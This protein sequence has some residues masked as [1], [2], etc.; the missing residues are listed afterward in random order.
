MA[1]NEAFKEF[2]IEGK[3]A[4][5]I[6]AELP[7]G[8]AA[9][10][11]LAEAGA[12]VVLA[13]QEPGTGDKLKEL[14]KKISALGRKAV[15]QNQSALTR[16]DLSACMDLTVKQLGALDI[17]VNALDVPFF[18]P[19]E[20]TDDTAFEKVIDNNLKTFWMACQEAGRTMVNRGGGVI[21]NITSIMAERGVPNASLYGAAQAAVLN[22]TRGLAL[23]W[24]RKSV[25]VNAIE[26]GWVEDPRS[27]AVSD[28]A[29]SQSLVKYLP[30][31]R[32]L[33]PEELG[34]ALLYLVSPAAA[35]VTGQSIAIDGG[36]LCRV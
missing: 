10:Q 13:S 24:A 5:V 1:V 23:E 18:A 7:L 4:L 28:E 9:A 20:A 16:A 31:Q 17:L 15:V 25:R 35:Y 12:N 22:L 6:G 3:A 29:F 26:M 27:P 2:S 19:V 34:G 14:A 30:D 36:L 33:K 11:T 8:A 32:L 21:V